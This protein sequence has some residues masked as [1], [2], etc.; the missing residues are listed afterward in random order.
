M[1]RRERSMKND[2]AGGRKL[3]EVLAERIE[4]EII[5]RGWPVGEVLGSE[6]ELIAK[7]DV[8]RAVFREAMRI[9]D[10]HGVAEMRR[11]PGGGLV[12]AKP[13]LEA[14]IRTVSLHLQFFQIAPS[15]VHETRLALELTAVRLATERMTPEG[16]ERIRQ[17]LAHEE[18]DIKRTRELDRPPGDLPTHDFHLL[19]AELTGNPAM[20]LFVQI[21]A[22]VTGV[23]SPRSPSLEETASEVHRVHTRIADAMLSG[24]V[25][26]AERRMRRHLETVL[27]Y[28][29]DAENGAAARRRVKP[30]PVPSAAS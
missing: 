28:L 8:S 5:A 16:A 24:D 29:T 11:G 25:A 15:Q 30:R 19:I 10:H 14:A 18:E 2:R 27:R 21:A 17:H 13:D 4:N 22:Q 26:A 1:P 7:Y 23:L 6:A 9:V 12:V 3:G 20:R